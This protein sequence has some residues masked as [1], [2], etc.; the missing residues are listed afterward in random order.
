VWKPLRSILEPWRAQPGWEFDLL[1]AL[2]AAVARPIYSRAQRRAHWR[3]MLTWKSWGFAVAL[4]ALVG[5]SMALVWAAAANLGL[6]PAGRI[7]LEIAFHATLGAVAFHPLVRLQERHARPYV[8]EALSA[9]LLGFARDRLVPPRGRGTR[10][11][12]AWGEGPAEPLGAPDTGRE[13]G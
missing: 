7:G 3:V 5:L 11:S 10:V 1:R 12:R 2:P 9:E 8:R 13:I 4:L 6:G